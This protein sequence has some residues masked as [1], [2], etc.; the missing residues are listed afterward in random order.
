MEWLRLLRDCR[1]VAGLWRRVAGDKVAEHSQNKER[2][3]RPHRAP[4][5]PQLANKLGRPRAPRQRNTVLILLG[6]RI[7]QEMCRGVPY[8]RQRGIVESEPATSATLRFEVEP[9]KSTGE[10][11]PGFGAAGRLGGAI[12]RPDD[13]QIRSGRF[14]RST[15]GGQCDCGQA[16]RANERQAAGLDRRPVIPSARQFALRLREA[17]EL[18]LVA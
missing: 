4:S 7:E 6:L 18:T 10:A 9:I 16:L 2:L 12:P 17:A 14:R 1:A 5:A 13:C 11:Q 15:P 3:F 8:R